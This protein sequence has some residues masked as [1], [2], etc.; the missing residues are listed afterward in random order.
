MSTL[1]L[2]SLKCLD[3]QEGDGDEIYFKFQDNGGSGTG[4]SSTFGGLD[5]GDFRYIYGSGTFSFNGSVKVTMFED[6]TFSDD[7]IQSANLY[8]P[9][10][11]SVTLGNSEMKYVLEY[12]IT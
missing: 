2:Y 6:D 12:F 7:N 3:R 8:N 1:Y 4:K 10:W 9:G 11:H 5:T